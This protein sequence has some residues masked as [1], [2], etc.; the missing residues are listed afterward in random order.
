[1]KRT[2]LITSLAVAAAAAL[3][4]SAQ[5]AFPG[6]NGRIAFTAYCMDVGDLCVVTVKPD[7]RKLK[8]LVTGGYRPAYSPSGKLLAFERGGEL[9][10]MKASGG[11]ERKVARGSSPAWSPDGR[12]LAFIRFVGNGSYRARTIKLDGT[13]LRAVGKR[14]ADAVAW[15]AAGELALRHRFSVYEEI[16]CPNVDHLGLTTTIVSPAGV[17]R[18]RL[19]GAVTATDWSPSGRRLVALAGRQTRPPAQAADS[20]ECDQTVAGYPSLAVTIFSRTGSVIRRL[21]TPQTRAF[22][23]AYSPDGHRIAYDDGSSLQVMRAD[24][25]RK[26]TI[27]ASSDVQSVVADSGLSWQPL[28]R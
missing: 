5:A 27:V 12:R 6:R 3:V 11:P 4:P 1:M 7:G 2:V 18:R 25:S 15:S 17:L 19:A 24:G 28:P 22:D 8:R 9:F 10:V 20:G 14:P 21:T 23:L 13:D 26:R 16:G